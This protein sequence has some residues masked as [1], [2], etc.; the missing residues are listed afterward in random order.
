[1]KGVEVSCTAGITE[2]G[3]WI[4]LFPIP[5]RFLESDKRFKKYQYIEANVAK[6]E[7]DP[8]PE[9]YKI[10][11]G[12]IKILPDSISPIDKWKNRKSIIFPLQS[13]SLCYLQ[14]ERN[15][16]KEPTLGFFKPKVISSFKIK[17]TRSFWNE[18]E[19]AKL[20]QYSLF[21]NSPATQLEK[22]PY[23]FFY[24]FKCDEPGCHGHLLS[25]T[26]WEMGASYLSWRA[27]YGTK[28]EDKF[29]ET[30]ETKMILEYDTYFF[31]GT[32]RTH[33][34]A[35]IIIGLFYPPM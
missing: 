7:S 2:D 4:R 21:N 19:M 24:E 28:W 6:S 16:N 12:S 26:D 18:E 8:R 32:L 10:D 35:W 11:I 1:M 34:D 17:P 3:K 30:Y 22:L 9:S 25:C 31:V 5:Y 20:K 27:K 15:L 29:R 23:D 33:P 14:N 13:R